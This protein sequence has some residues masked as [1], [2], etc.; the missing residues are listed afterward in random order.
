MVRVKGDTVKLSDLE[1][2]VV[3]NDDEISQYYDP[4]ENGYVYRNNEENQ[5]VLIVR[6]NGEIRIPVEANIESAVISKLLDDLDIDGFDLNNIGTTNT[7]SIRSLSDIDGSVV[8]NTLSQIDGAGLSIIDGDLVVTAEFEGIQGLTNPLVENLNADGYNINNVGTVDA[9]ALEAEQISNTVVYASPFSDLE[10]A[11]SKAESENIPTV[12]VAP[13]EFE[14][15]D[16]FSLDVNLIG[17][18][19]DQTTIHCDEIDLGDR[20]D[21]VRIAHLTV[22]GSNN[23]NAPILTRGDGVVMDTI[24]VKN[25]NETGNETIR[26]LSDRTT[27]IKCVIEAED[28]S[29]TDVLRLSSDNNFVI[30]NDIEDGVR[31]D[32]SGNYPTPFGDFNNII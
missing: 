29:E 18:G 6:E 2:I 8:S 19:I 16:T 24:R 3:G 23:A 22:T 10:S 17:S 7:D 26:T 13:G 28:P 4:S 15:D 27:I 9:Q 5:D 1:E 25:E 11:I 30:G 21:N 14:L 20:V 12:V 31:D 32:G